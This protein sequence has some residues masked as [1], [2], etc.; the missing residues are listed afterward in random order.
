[1]YDIAVLHAYDL[2]MHYNALYTI[3]SSLSSALGKRQEDR[4]QKAKARLTLAKE[5]LRD[6]QQ[7]MIDVKAGSCLLAH[8]EMYLGSNIH[9][10]SRL[11]C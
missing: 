8:H 1:M 3:Y 4:L 2:Y 6:L 5:S 7:Q 9:C 10:M 11:F